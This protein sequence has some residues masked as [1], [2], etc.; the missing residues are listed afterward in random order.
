L[1]AATT[2]SAADAHIAPENEPGEP[3]VLEGRVTTPDGKAAAGIVVYAYHTD[4]KGIYPPVAEG[5]RLRHG[6]LRGW[7]R[8]GA[9]GTYRFRTI[10]PAPY[11]SGGIAA[12]IHMHVLEPGRGTFR[13]EQP[14]RGGGAIVTATRDTKGTWHIR[15]DIELGRNIPDYPR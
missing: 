13:R 1:K 15:R 3:L 5:P 4:N 11:P 10:R 12:H 2:T 14:G 7:A 6:R 9:D 8:T